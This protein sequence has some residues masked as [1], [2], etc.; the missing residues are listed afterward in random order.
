MLRLMELPPM[1]VRSFAEA[2]YALADR[3][4]SN[5]NLKNCHLGSL[6]SFRF[7]LPESQSVVGHE[8]L[9]IRSGSPFPGPERHPGLAGSQVLQVLLQ[10]LLDVCG[11]SE[12]HAR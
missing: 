1:L 10:S 4:H 12:I 2:L 9:L 6:K 7:C 8:A 11:Q 3:W 5:A